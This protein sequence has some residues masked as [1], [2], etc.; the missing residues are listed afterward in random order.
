MVSPVSAGRMQARS[1]TVG[2]AAGSSFGIC[3]AVTGGPTP[4]L[5]WQLNGSNLPGETAACLYRSNVQSNHSGNY[6]LVASNIAGV[7][8]SA[9]I[10]IAVQYL[11]PTG[12]VYF[13]GGS[14]PALAGTA[15][16]SWQNVMIKRERDYAQQQEGLAKQRAAEAKAAQG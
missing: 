5:Q 11:P 2:L 1:Q 10:Y 15:V 4:S 9:P 13:A 6:Q 7:Y 12:N 3:S 14:S 16:T 8:T